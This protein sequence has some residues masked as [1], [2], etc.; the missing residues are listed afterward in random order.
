MKPI[1]IN[2]YPTVR[3]NVGRAILFHHTILTNHVIATDF[4]DE[5]LPDER[6]NGNI[7]KLLMSPETPISC[8]NSELAVAVVPLPAM[9]PDDVLVQLYDCEEY[10]WIQNSYLDIFQLIYVRRQPIHIDRSDLAALW[11]TYYNSRE[12]KDKITT[13]GT[14]NG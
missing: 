5:Y 3:R 8:L 14:Y 10:S 12:T 13:G 11:H 1:T 2:A 9:N 6:Y 4:S 7:L